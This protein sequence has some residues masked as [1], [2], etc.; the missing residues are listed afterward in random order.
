MADTGHKTGWEHFP[1]TASIRYHNKDVGEEQ[2][3]F[4]VG[5]EMLAFPDFE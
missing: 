2:L 5:V 3:Q 4:Y 1:Y